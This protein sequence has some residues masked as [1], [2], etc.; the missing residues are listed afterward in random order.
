[1]TIPA[2]RGIAETTAPFVVKAPCRFGVLDLETRRSAQ[3][4]GGWGNAARM[5][6]SCV[7]VYDSKTDR[8]EE[9]L[10]DAIPRLVEH[11]KTFDLV[12]G[13]N[14]SRFDY[15]VLR[16]NNAFNFHSLPTLDMLTEVHK[17]LGYRLS[18]DH[19]GENT[20][21][22]RKS[23]DGLMALAWWKEG[24]IREIVDYC[25]Q[26]VLVTRDLYLFGR[27]KGYLLFKNKAGMKVRV[28]VAW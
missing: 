4:V 9:Y 23:A 20:L 28:P 22:V 3:E 10:G 21:G 25:R 15:A 1:M 5:G 2:P 6:I 11:L 14:I 16:G 26:D 7:V 17:R 19:L 8:F 18:L 27:D 24:K 12:V 13:F